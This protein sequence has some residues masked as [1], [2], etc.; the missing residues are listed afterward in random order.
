[1]DAR[2]FADEPM[3]L[4]GQMLKRP[5]TDRFTYDHQQEVF[6][7]DFTGLS[8]RTLDDIAQL[9]A[10]A[11][12]KLKPIGHKVDAVVNYDRMSIMPEL[13]DAYVEAIKDIVSSYY[14]EVTRYSA[15]SFLR[16]KLGELLDN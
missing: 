10:E 4:R 6:F 14:N 9:K 1:M 5:L 15:N 8:I 2:I 7:V 13:M 16:M 3:Q 11:E 12:R